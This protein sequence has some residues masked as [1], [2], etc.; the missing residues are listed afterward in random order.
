MSIDIINYIKDNSNDINLHGHG[1]V[2]FDKETVKAI[3]QGMSTIGSQLGLSATMVGVS[4]TVGKAVVKSGMPPLQKAGLIVG[5]SALGGLFH[6]KISS[7]N[8]SQVAA[9]NAATTTTTSIL[10]TNID[11]HISKLVDDSHISALQELLLNLEITIC[12]L[13]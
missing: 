11:S 6:S 7:I 2:T 8:R 10:S 5:A 1:H 9:E 13:T 4:T 12:M 3:G